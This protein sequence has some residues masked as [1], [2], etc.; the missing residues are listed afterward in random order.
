MIPA[1]ASLPVAAQRLALV[2]S[3]HEETETAVR[4]LL[5]DGKN[6]KPAGSLLNA[7][8][9]LDLDTRWEGRVRWSEFEEVVYLDGQPIDDDALTAVALWLDRVYM[10]RAAPDNLMRALTRVAKEHRFHPVR[11]WLDGLAWDGTPRV[12]RLVATYLRGADTPLNRLVAAAWMV[13]AVARIYE[14]G[15]K[16]DNLL[17][18]VGG[19]GEF[20][21]Q[22]VA[23]LCPV[24]S[25]LSDTP[26]VVGD[27]DAYGLV[28]GIWIYELA[29]LKALRGASNEGIKAFLSS[30]KDRFRRPYG[31]IPEM[32]LRSVA[33]VGTT[34]L[35]EFLTDE[36]G[37]RRFWPVFV[38]RADL[39][40]IK[41]DRDQ[42]WA[43]AVHRYRAGEKW[44]LDAAGDA[45]LKQ[46]SMKHQVT[47]AWFGIIREWLDD[48]PRF[49]MDDVLG[50]AL[51]I[52]VERWSHSAVT[53]I[54]GILA[55]L[56]CTKDRPGDDS[57]ERP[58][59][60]NRPEGWTS[61]GSGG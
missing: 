34:N 52:P 40:A 60:Y 45:L 16:F 1:H 13:G 58:R 61:G 53:R 17:I 59:F 32:H 49:T 2:E 15:C 19:Q 43:E 30:R 55:R 23:A 56:G 20:K 31:R 26:F 47:E 46:V 21:S 9:V 50:D 48:H 38:G 3:D 14:P 10:L 7:F 29:E 8:T 24:Q 36:T 11:D 25:W 12:D 27:K 5:D 28:Q 18:L 33:F 6:G 39:A 22:A 35:E 54:G 44:W 42:L 51:G 57:R 41:R 4:E 37:S